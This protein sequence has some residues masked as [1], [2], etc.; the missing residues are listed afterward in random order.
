MMLPVPGTPRWTTRRGHRLRQSPVSSCFQTVRQRTGLYLMATAP[1][2]PVWTRTHRRG[3][4]PTGCLP[5]RQSPC[6]TDRRWGAKRM[7]TAVIV[8]NTSF[9]WR[10]SNTLRTSTTLH[11]WLGVANGAI[12]AACFTLSYLPSFSISM[13]LVKAEHRLAIVG[14]MAIQHSIRHTCPAPLLTVGRSGRATS[15]LPGAGRHRHTS[16]CAE[17]RS[18]QPELRRWAVTFGRCGCCIYSARPGLSNRG[19]APEQMPPHMPVPFRQRLGRLR[20]RAGGA[21]PGGPQYGGR[22]AL[23][24]QPQLRGAS[25]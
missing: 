19:P 10:L 14:K 7:K 8:T 6:W 4:L 13:V 25:R 17:R 18:S 16:R 2:P 23:R 15:V 11:R 1:G 20:G 5:R 22:G 24:R 21:S 12:V 3:R 9:L